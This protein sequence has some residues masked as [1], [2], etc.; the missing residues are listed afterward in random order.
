MQSQN[1]R[2]QNYGLEEQ[3]QGSTGIGVLERP[4]TQEEKPG[5]RDRFA[6][7]VAANRLGAARMSGQPV[8]ALCGK[9]WVPTREGHGHPICPRCKE[10][11]DDMDKNGGV[12]WPFRGPG[13]R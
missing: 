1:Q 9:V 8:V 6:H 10:I 13:E 11:K 4:E 2:P 12:D 7:Y 5:D 3:T